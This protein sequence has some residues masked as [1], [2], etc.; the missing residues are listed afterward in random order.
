MDPARVSPSQD[1][2]SSDP[3]P[4]VWRRREPLGYASGLVSFASVAAPLLTGF[5]LTTIVELTGRDERGTRGDIAIAAFA[6]AAGLLIYAIQAGLAAGQLAI[7]PDQRSAQV[8]EARGYPEWMR[9]L[10]EDQWRDATLAERLFTRTRIAYNLGL[11]AFLAGLTATL[12]PGPGDWT[13]IRIAAVAAA[14]TAGGIEIVLVS[15]HLRP[16]SH[17]LLPTLDSTPESRAE[18]SNDQPVEMDDASVQRLVYGASSDT[19]NKQLPHAAGSDV[20]IALTT[21][22]AQLASL[23]GLLARLEVTVREATRRPASDR[24][25]D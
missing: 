11:L 25:D 12:I 24:D 7:A 10:R 8:P 13:P 9:R 19:I 18:A 17:W 6:I 2:A 21:L 15:G 20:T 1:G 3:L 23:T 14:G 22:T 4:A 5:A 16:V